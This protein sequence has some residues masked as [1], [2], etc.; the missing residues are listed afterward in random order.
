M[1]VLANLLA[2]GWEPELRGYLSVIIGAVALGGSVYLILGTNLGSRL[3]F[4]VTLAGLFGWMAVMGAVWWTYGI[5][6]MG[7]LPSW[8]P[9]NPVAIVRDA[10]LLHQAD[11][12]GEPIRSQ[13]LSAGELDAFVTN[14]LT[15]QGWTRLADSDPA[16]G[17]AIAAAEDILVNQAGEFS[18][19][20]FLPRAVYDKGGDRFPKINET[21]DFLAFLHKPYYALVE[22]APVVPQYVEPGRAPAR[23]IVD[24]SQPRRYVVMVRDLGTHRQPA[25][26]TTLGSTGIFV[27]LCWMLHRRERTLIANRRGDTGEKGEL[28]AAKE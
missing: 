26:F 27:I 1:P 24:E 9:A 5:G 25:A 16:R 15:Q 12:V 4:L 2:I 14:A 13:G 21:L 20:E 18:A 11:V 8:E 3:G 28:L 17:Q 19:G 22:V 6:L 23:P 10:S 7:R